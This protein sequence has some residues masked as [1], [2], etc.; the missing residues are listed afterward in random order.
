M[1]EQS[2]KNKK[3]QK[4]KKEKKFS[5]PQI[6]NKKALKNGGYS[7][8]LS[9][10]M[11][12]VVIVVNLVVGQIP[13]KY[14][15]FDISTGKLYTIGDDTKNVLNNLNEDITI[16]YIVQSGN[17]D[18]N[19]EKLLEQYEE[20]SSHI[21]VE[22]KDPVVYPS[23]VSKYTDESIA[24]N[25]LIVVGAD[26]NKIVSASSIYESEI[27][28]YTYQ[29]TITA[30]DGEGQITS[31]IAYVT[32]EELPVLY[33]VDGHNEVS[34]PEALTERIEKANV[35]LQSLSLLTTD[36]IPEDAAGILLNSPGTDYSTEEAEKIINYL[37][38]GGKAMIITDYLGNDLPNYQSI[39]EEY[40]IQVTDGIVIENDKNKYV[41]KPYYLVPDISS[42]EVTSDMTGGSHYVLLTGCQSFSLAE[43]ARDTLNISQI[44]TTSDNS[45]VKTDPQ[46][47]TTYDKED[48]DVDGPCTVGAVIS[49]TVNAA[50][51]DSEDADST[52]TD[53]EEEEV[54]SADAIAAED[55]T[56]SA[57]VDTEETDS[58][59]EED[60]DSTDAVQT[61]T[62]QIVCF[63]SSAILDDSVNEMVSDGN[64]T[65][66]MNSLNWMVDAQED[67]SIVSIASKSV[68]VSYLTVTAGKA[69]FFAVILC[70]LLPIACLIVGGV[71]CYRRKRR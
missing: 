9:V 62:T 40:G 33:Y 4:I 3:E 58:T 43:D 1:S 45:Y 30:F 66:Y 59:E 27:N 70:F 13:S 54:D 5:L 36:E 52:D 69:A 39:L 29:E 42:S 10:I 20:N 21:K 25:S 11:I 57:D 64:Y 48:G 50:A 61:K 22:K 53:A 8:V 34:L 15:Q 37:K 23:F 17:E 63:A 67:T 24:D 35:E 71:I 2:K 12:A 51:D 47:M 16:Y 55:E 6:K 68:E 7:V 28:Y 32:S 56:D 19:I 60:V 41:Q 18:T 65:L 49:E 46:N 14:T 31:A 44:L 26:R 38:N